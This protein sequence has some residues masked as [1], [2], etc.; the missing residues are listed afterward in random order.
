[1]GELDHLMLAM[2]QLKGVVPN[3][4]E[5]CHHYYGLLRRPKAISSMVISVAVFVMHIKVYNT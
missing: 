3:N 1:V 2:I 5:C 4:Y